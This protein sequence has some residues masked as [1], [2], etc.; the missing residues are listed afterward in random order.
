[1]YRAKLFLDELKQWEQKGEFPNLVY[2]FL[3]CRPHQRHAA[4]LADAAGDGRGQR[5]GARAWWSRRCSKSKFWPKTCI[6]VTEDDPQN[7]FDHV[8]GHRTVGLVDFAVHQAQGGRF[9]LL[10]PDRDGEDD[11]ADARACRR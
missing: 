2:L 9:D 3:P 1:M 4:R 8:D 11:R 10:Q 7:G 5:P 6:V